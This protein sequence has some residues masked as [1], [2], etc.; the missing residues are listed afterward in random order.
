MFTPDDET[1]LEAI[2]RVSDGAVADAIAH[3][4]SKSELDRTLANHKHYAE[5]LMVA[6]ELSS[7]LDTNQLIRKIIL[8][9]QSFVSADR[10]SLFLVDKVRGGLWSL[11]ASGAGDRIYIPAGAGIAGYVAQTGQILNIPDAYQDSRFNP[12]HDKAT[13]YRTKSVLCVPIMDNRGSPLGC[14]Q[15]INKVGGGEFTTEDADLM[16]AFNV[17]CGIALSN[18]QLYD[19]ATQS[20]KKITTL[21]EMTMQLAGSDPFDKVLQSLSKSVCDLLDCDHCWIADISHVRH[22]YR[23]FGARSELAIEL[24]VMRG[25]LGF[26]AMTGAE[27]RVSDP[28]SDQRYEASTFLR[29]DEMTGMIGLPV[30]NEKGEI[31]GS[32]IAVNKRGIPTFT[33][34]DLEQLRAFAMLLTLAFGRKTPDVD[35]DPLIVE[36]ITLREMLMAEVGS[37]CFSAFEISENNQIRILIHFLNEL[38]ITR[39]FSI[40]P[41]T[42]LSFMKAVCSAYNHVPFRNWS[43]AVDMA[44]FLFFEI[45]TAAMTSIMTKLELFAVVVAAICHSIGYISPT[46]TPI[47]RTALHILHRGQPPAETAYCTRA[48]QLMGLPN[49]NILQ[50][51]DPKGQQ[52]FWEIVVGC[53]LVLNSTQRS[54]FIHDLNHKLRS[55]TIDLGKP[56]SRVDVL[57]VM[58]IAADFAR[59]I[60]PFSHSDPWSKLFSEEVLDSTIGENV[61]GPDLPVAKLAKREADFASRDVKPVV[62]LLEKVVPGLSLVK[63]QFESNLRKWSQ[64]AEHS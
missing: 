10:C 55:E 5:L 30:R 35:T 2:L 8:S 38:G 44:Q 45:Q 31:I 19:N 41:F 40:S 7:V 9:A 46:V 63:D 37:F 29:S 3:E 53:I 28:R 54:E 59:V 36:N 52:S 1:L 20:K 23:V 17:F 16:S 27:L 24:S 34:D 22:V 13:G 42:S 26:V 58:L 14:T 39:E 18:A 6:Q 21:L 60:R 32:V 57:K 43:R 25:V 33:N 47:R 15:M 48:V 11:V 49:C 4:Q 61:L 64:I 51:I 56:T 12:A 62:L 50:N